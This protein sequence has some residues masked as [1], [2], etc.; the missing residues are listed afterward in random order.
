MSNKKL[1]LFA[2]SAAMATGLVFVG[3]K[4]VESSTRPGVVRASRLE[5]VGS[6]GQIVARLGT[7][8]RDRPVMALLQLD[9]SVGLSV[10]LTGGEP[11]VS[12]IGRDGKPRMV[13]YLHEDFP[14]LGMGD[15]GLEGKVMLG[16]LPM[17][18]PGA[19]PTSWLLRFR[20]QSGWTGAS[21]G[22][23][24]PDER[25]G[26]LYLRDSSGGAHRLPPE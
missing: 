11:S 22:L 3:M 21:I 26:V 16:A 25:G 12:L 4:L 24:T 6:A 8:D 1:L 5:L 9:G 15:G 18:T 23:R 19:K 13:L 20:G 14:V 17:D 10:S 7:D 2:V